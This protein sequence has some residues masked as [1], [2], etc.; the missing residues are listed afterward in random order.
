MTGF[1]PDA[2]ITNSPISKI[3]YRRTR[4]L[5]FLFAALRTRSL[6]AREELARIATK[7][8]LGFTELLTAM[9]TQLAGGEVDIEINS[10]RKKAFVDLAW[11]LAN[12][13]TD[14]HPSKQPKGHQI[15]AQKSL[16]VYRWVIEFLGIKRFHQMHLID[17]LMLAIRLGDEDLSNTVRPKIRPWL[18]WIPKIAPKKLKTTR[19]LGIAELLNIGFVFGKDFSL[20]SKLLLVDSEN[21]FRAEPEPLKQLE[22]SNS[23]LRKLSRQLLP[24]GAAELTFGAGFE[25]PFD[26]LSTKSTKP[27]VGKR[28]V[29]VI[30]S[31]YKPTKAIISSVNSILASSYQNLEVLVIDDASPRTYE[32]ILSEVENLD[33][34]VRVVRQKENG[35]TYRIR[36]RALGE[37]KGELVTFHDS[38]DWMHP[39]RIAWQEKAISG[40]KVANVSMS[41]RVTEML[42]CVES[43]RRLRIGICEP[44]L[45]FLRK[46]V[47][48]KIGFFDHVRKGAD[49]EYRKR[50]E[51]AFGQDLDIIAPF[52]A[53]TLQRAD[54]GGLTDGDLG[55]RWIVDYRLRYKDLYL[56]WHRKSEVLHLPAGNPRKFYAPRQMRFRGDLAT[57]H[58]DK[59]LVIGANFCDQKNVDFIAEAINEALAADKTVG[60]WHIPTMYP[61]ALTRTLRPR[62]MELLNKGKAQLVYPEDNLDIGKLWLASPSAYLVSRAKVVF[63]WKIAEFDFVNIR[64]EPETWN[65]EGEKLDQFLHTELL[66]LMSD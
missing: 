42:E 18:F 13:P 63:N 26:S 22:S 2:R 59:D 10:R 44:S 34:R 21:P 20:S 38:D 45:M 35:G 5:R 14:P 25:N 29:T 7:D 9:Q 43:G 3:S 62:V 4:R 41:T 52:K 28:L 24:K 60:F 12:Q 40:Q 8:Q 46:P 56:N 30:V 49:S 66:G 54:H 58:R 1:A 19:A 37:A 57:K 33:L 51:K 11:L 15:D 48:S 64:E 65:V 16:I 61:L 50:I 39:Q 53:L 17:A 23:W 27:V 31:C 6:S 55:F 36:N 47:V 32:E